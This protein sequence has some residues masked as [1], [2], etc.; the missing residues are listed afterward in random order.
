[1]ISVGIPKIALS[2]ENLQEELLEVTESCYTTDLGLVELKD[3]D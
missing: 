3:I 1:M 2:F